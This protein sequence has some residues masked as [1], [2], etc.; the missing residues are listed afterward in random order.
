MNIITVRG[1]RSKWI[2]SG[3]SGSVKPNRIKPIIGAVIHHTATFSDQSCIN[4]FTNPINKNASAHYLVGLQGKIW[5]FVQE[6]ERAW[7]A[8]KSQIEI[9]GV[10]Y[11]S[12]NEFS[13]GYELTGDGNEVPYTDY[14]Y[15]SLAWLLSRAVEKYGI[16]REFIVGHEQ[17]CPGRKT[18]P[19]IH[20]DWERLFTAVFG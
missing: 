10:I 16:T 18:D 7:H 9:N 13:L 6:D 3:D 4:W 8:G 15:E 12:W 1:C 19:G 14:Q 20:F 5:Q 2:V 11:S 17:I